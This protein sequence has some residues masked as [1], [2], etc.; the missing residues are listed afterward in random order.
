MSVSKHDIEWLINVISEYEDVLPATL[1]QSTEN[2]IADSNY[3][4]S[5]CVIHPVNRKAYDSVRKE[6]KTYLIAE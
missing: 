3:R 1:I 4:K 2:L 6:I 5:V